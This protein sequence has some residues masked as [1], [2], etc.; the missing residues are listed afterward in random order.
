VFTR[1][2]FLLLLTLV[3]HASLAGDIPGMPLVLPPSGSA[4]HWVSWS[5][6]Y[7]GRGGATDDHRTQQLGL[8]LSIAPRWALIL[9]HSILT[10]QS[11]TNT[12]VQGTRLDQLSTSLGYTL[13]HSPNA[14]QTI[15]ELIAGVGLRSYGNFSGQKM[16]HGFHRLLNSE[17]EHFDYLDARRTDA[18]VWLRAN[19][20]RL[21]PL[22]SSNH[23]AWRTG[24]WL[25]VSGLYSSDQQWDAALAF[26]G[27]LATAEITG[28]LGL[29]VDW[30]QH[31]ERD[32]LTHAVAES[33][34]GMGISLGFR[35][36]PV[37][38]ETVQGLGERDSWGRLVFHSRDLPSG[39]GEFYPLPRH[40]LALNLLFPDVEAQLRYRYSLSRLP[41]FFAA[42]QLWL[43]AEIQG[44]KPAVEGT[45]CCYRQARQAGIGVELEWRKS[46]AGIQAWP[47]LNAAIVQREERLHVDNGDYAGQ[48]SQTVNS[49]LLQLEAG[50][51]IHLYHSKTLWVDFQTG[52]VGQLSS[53]TQEV[54][55]GSQQAILNRSRL[56]ITTG[57][58]IGFG[59]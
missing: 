18:V 14:T 59:I 52:F 39:A 36:G 25:E 38:L 9:D 30:R 3:W 43:M 31:Y 58:S 1:L 7:F 40:N 49:T 6:D 54:Q 55:A 24:Y 32:A 46:H 19:R 20:E 45:T 10:L 35:I 5:N 22:P 13:F 12:G 23:T 26:N 21:Y 56:L 48:A 37:S 33:E 17:I 44:G 8:G 51:R 50:Y 29:R 27:V 2:T 4:N 42:P 15:D 34:S 28:W 41:E 47:Y 16:Q 57:L 11:V 53:T